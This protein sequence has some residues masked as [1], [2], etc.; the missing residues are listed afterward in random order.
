[1]SQ[2]GSADIN[3]D[4]DDVTNNNNDP[5]AASA[6]AASASILK[7]SWNAAIEEHRESCEAL[8]RVQ[9]QLQHPLARDTDD[10]VPGNTD[11][12]KQRKEV[13]EINDIIYKIQE[14]EN[15]LEADDDDDNQNHPTPFLSLTAKMGWE[16]IAHAKQQAT[17]K[18]EQLKSK[19]TAQ[20]K[21]RKAAIEELQKL[22]ERIRRDPTCRH[23]T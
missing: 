14:V 6:A 19:L 18:L 3:T 2:E 8:C 7:D 11:S 5:A 13:C 1:M 16:E 10:D 4:D 22:R 17:N 9:Q 20:G 12:N 15:K 21:R 23:A